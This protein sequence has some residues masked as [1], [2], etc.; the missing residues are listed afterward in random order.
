MTMILENPP[1]SLL[2]TE[3]EQLTNLSGRV[4]CLIGIA[5]EIALGLTQAKDGGFNMDL[6]HI[7]FKE[8]S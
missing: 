3:S 7:F 6:S 4:N 2:T 5:Q 1:E 8:Q